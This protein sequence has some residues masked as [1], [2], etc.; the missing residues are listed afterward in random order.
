VCGGAQRS[1]HCVAQAHVLAHVAAAQARAAGASAAHSWTVQLRAATAYATRKGMAVQL[2]PP[3]SATCVSHAPSPVRLAPLC[4]PAA[5]LVDAVEVV[6]HALDRH[7]LAILDAL[8][9]EHLTEGALAFLGDQPV[10]CAAGHTSVEIDWSSSSMAPG[11]VT[12]VVLAG[13]REQGRCDRARL[14]ARAQP[15]CAASIG[16]AAD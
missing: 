16:W 5:H 2:S 13:C 3:A 8:G 12:L 10:L 7:V 1:Q 6:L 14:R 4:P 11:I 9:L 15:A